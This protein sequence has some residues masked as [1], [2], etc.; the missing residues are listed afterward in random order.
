MKKLLVLA[1][2]TGVGK[3][4]LGLKIAEHYRCDIISVD[5]RQLYKGLEI[6]TAAP[7]G[8][9]RARVVHHFAGVLH[10]DEYYSASDYEQAAIAKIEELH[11]AN[12]V[13]LATGGSMMYVDALC[14]GVDTMPSIDVK[15][16]TELYQQYEKEG[17][18]NMLS[19]LRLLDPVHY[20]QVDHKNPKR[21]IHALE[22]C[23]QTGQPYSR[24]R[25]GIRKERPFEIIRIGIERQ[26]EELYQRINTRVDNMIA[27]GL[28]QEAERF[29]SQKNLNALNT[30]GYK[31]IFK[32]LDGDW[33][34]EHAIEKIKQN[35]RTYAKQ[36]M[37]WFKKDDNTIWFNLSAISEDDVIRQII[38]LV[39]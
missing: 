32:Y 2:P 1:G 24:F 37:R 21:V 10:V 18:A 25:T 39:G 23:L 30:V 35:T 11:Q 9:Q 17:L 19:R 38:H 29:Y 8:E 12:D 15:L 28:L 22:V 31:E 33:T 34:L 5:S 26:R 27:S 4:E 36:Q 14:Y 6:A 7:T 20:D 13:V 3:T 16:R